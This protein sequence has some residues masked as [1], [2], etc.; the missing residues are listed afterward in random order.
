MT[1]ALGD[2]LTQA[3]QHLTEAARHHDDLPAAAQAD[4]IIERDR[5][6]TVLTTYARE[7]L[8]AAGTEPARP[9][10][11]IPELAKTGV[12]VLIERAAENLH[13]AALALPEAAAAHARHPMADRI[14]AAAACLTVGRDLI[15]TYDTDDPR[16]RTPQLWAPVMNSAPVRTALTRELRSE[17]H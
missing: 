5:L 10:P 3:R 4:A 8:H 1:P 7:G 12:G 15:R 17:E 11:S 9:I 2:F 6:L 14:S 13:Q 16:P